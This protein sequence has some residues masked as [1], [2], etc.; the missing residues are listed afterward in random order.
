MIALHGEVLRDDAHRYWLTTAPVRRE[1]VGVSAVLKD[2]GFVDDARFTP[3]SR[4]RGHLVHTITEQ[5]DADDPTWCVWAAED[6][7]FSAYAESYERLLDEHRPEWWLTETIVYDPVLGY[8]GTLDRF[9]LVNADT[10]A[11][12]DFKSGKTTAAHALQTAAYKRCIPDDW[13]DVLERAGRLSAARAAALRVKRANR[14]LLMKRFTIELQRD[15]SRARFVPHADL[16]DQVYFLAALT[17]YQ[18]R[19]Q[20]VRNRSD[21]V[22][23]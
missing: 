12:G 5:I 23:V 19:Q 7:V 10:L 6:P 8:A 22:A 14:T 16:Q 17:C 9:G 15:G 20:H 2:A 11:V 1:L 18:W 3:D 4:D 13:I 21:G